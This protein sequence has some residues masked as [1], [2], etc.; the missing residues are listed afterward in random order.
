MC[1][2]EHASVQP[3]IF[4]DWRR[5]ARMYNNASLNL[6]KNEMVDNVVVHFEITMC[7]EYHANKCGMLKQ[8]FNVSSVKKGAHDKR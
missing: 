5:S 8:W 1:I 3:F 7:V 2:I 4:D 6:Y